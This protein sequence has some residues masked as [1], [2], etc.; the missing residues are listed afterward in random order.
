LLGTSHA[1]HAMAWETLGSSPLAALHAELGVQVYANEGK[2][3]CD[4]SC[5]IRCQAA[6]QRGYPQALQMLLRTRGEIDDSSEGLWAR[7]VS[8]LLHERAL[9]RGELRRAHAFQ[10]QLSALAPAKGS[11]YLPYAVSRHAEIQ[12]LLRSGRA[13]DAMRKATE[14]HKECEARML[15]LECIKCLQ[16][17]ADAC[18]ACDNPSP[19]LHYAS[20]SCALAEAHQA[21]THAA[22]ATVSLT[23]ALLRMGLREQASRA[24]E[25]KMPVILRDAP[26]LVCGK[27]H[28]VLAKCQINEGSTEECRAA[29]EELEAAKACFCELAAFLELEETLYLQARM[30]HTLGM[31]EERNE[32]S[33]SFAF[34]QREA[35]V[36]RREEETWGVNYGDCS[37][38]L[39]LELE[40]VQHKHQLYQTQI[41]GVVIS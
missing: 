30:Y 35:A 40:R 14:F 26:L 31:I 27:A 16:A 6:L 8:H 32:A 20:R 21:D 23:G 15:P 33:K 13:E 37:R 11:D 36:C 7:A 12:L 17:L 3:P 38:A 28:L 1:V 10:V 5:L 22:A 25:A 18:L 9:L 34:V 19:A 2:M 39:E 41:M 4:E 24:L 29:V